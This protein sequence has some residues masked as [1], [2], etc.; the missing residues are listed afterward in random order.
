MKYN[1]KDT[2]GFTLLE[3]LVSLSIIAIILIS[4]FR[5]QSS[6]INLINSEK[7]Y[8]IALYLAQ[9][10]IAEI[11]SKLLISDESDVSGDFGKNFPKY[12]WKYSISNFIFSDT[13]II[14]K[15][16]LEN[17]KKINLDILYQDKYLF[18]I[19]TWKF[20]QNE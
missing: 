17:F 15:K 4:L 9:K 3:I 13:D 20:I 6:N 10:K 18:K 2:N 11:E 1:I 12:K 14:S 7:F 19:S 8:S 16:G 5:M